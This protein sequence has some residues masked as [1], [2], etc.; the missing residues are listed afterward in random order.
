MTSQSYTLKPYIPSDVIPKDFINLLRNELVGKDVID[1]DI[2]V[3]V[4][5]HELILIKNTQSPG[6]LH[7][8]AHLINLLRW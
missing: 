3:N 2:F 8:D 5:T 6:Q 1:H 4:G 7:H